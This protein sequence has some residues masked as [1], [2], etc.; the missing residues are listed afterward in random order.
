MDHGHEDIGALWLERQ[1]GPEV[2]MPVRLHVAAKRYLCTVE[3][4]IERLCCRCHLY[5]KTKASI[6]V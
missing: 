6:P 5:E 3:P 1:F 2:T 4:G